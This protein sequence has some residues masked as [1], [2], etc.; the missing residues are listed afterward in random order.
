MRLAITTALAAL[1]LSTPLPVEAFDLTG[2]WVG[3]WS[4]VGTESGVKF[5]DFDKES[6]AAVTSLGN[7]T[8][9]AILDGN[10]L[11]HGIEI[12]D[13][14]KPDKGEIAIAHCGSSDDF[15]QVGS[16]VFFEAGRFKVSTKGAKGSMKGF[17]LYS[18]GP[19]HVATCKYKYKRVDTTNPNLTYACP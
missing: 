2:N 8:F 15:T 14:T 10:L 3:S 11:F 19:G 5:K 18:F 9:G 12:P 4:C 13:A 7:N 17:T 6:T 16:F 1:S